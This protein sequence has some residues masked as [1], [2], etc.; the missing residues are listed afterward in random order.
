MLLLIC[1]N[2]LLLTSSNSSFNKNISS[3]SNS[4]ANIFSPIMFGNC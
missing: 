1:C 4:F 3:I 2:A